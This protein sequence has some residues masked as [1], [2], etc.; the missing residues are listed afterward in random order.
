MLPLPFLLALFLIGYIFG[1]IPF[2]LI[3]TRMAGL[4]DVRAIGSGNTGATNVLRTGRKGLAAA[5]LLLDMLKGL[6]AIIIAYL[7]FSHGGDRIPAIAAGSGALIGHIFPV[8]LKFRGGK[9]VATYIGVLVGMYWPA[10]LAFCLVWL[11]SAFLFRYSSLSALIASTV[12]PFVPLVTGALTPGVFQIS[13]ISGAL[14]VFSLII[15]ATHHENIA[16]LLKG[17]ESKIGARK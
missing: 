14:S 9:G 12:V 2:G 13:L 3:L 7:F 10:A 6:L 1:S 11:I 16:R 15:F 8:W 4:G 17:K 5:T